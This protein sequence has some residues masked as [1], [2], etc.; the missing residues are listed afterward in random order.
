MPSQFKSNQP[1]DKPWT[2]K[3]NVTVQDMPYMIS[4]WTNI[5]QGKSNGCTKLNINWTLEA[6]FEPCK[7][8]ANSTCNDHEHEVAIMLQTSN[9]Y[10]P[11]LDHLTISSSIDIM[12]IQDLQFKLAM[13]T[14]IQYLTNNNLRQN[15]IHPT[16]YNNNKGNEYKDNK[17]T[18]SYSWHL[19]KGHVHICCKLTIPSSSSYIWPFNHHHEHPE[20]IAWT[21]SIDQHIYCRKMM[22]N[23]DLRYSADLLHKSEYRKQE[24]HIKA[25]RRHEIQASINTTQVH[26]P[27]QL[28]SEWKAGA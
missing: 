22:Q 17:S 25:N 28:G 3:D 13:H 24:M 4:C 12:P 15:L 16:K 7:L 1:E 21:P 23:Q 9:D 6:C 26:I 5:D 8:V 20:S 10:I 27:L 14:I 18:T 2:N 19:T 11:A